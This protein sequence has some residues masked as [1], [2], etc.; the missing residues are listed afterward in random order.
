MSSAQQLAAVALVVAAA[1]VGAPA[2]A[3]TR[4]ATAVVAVSVRVL[5]RSS[6][7]DARDTTRSRAELSIAPARLRG[8]AGDEIEVHFAG[9]RVPVVVR[10]VPAEGVRRAAPGVYRGRATLVLAPL[11]Y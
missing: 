3:Q 4:V 11:R 6:V 1:A 5:S 8:P 2:S 9:A 10:A 7:G